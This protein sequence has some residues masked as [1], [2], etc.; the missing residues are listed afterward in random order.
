MSEQLRPQFEILYLKAISDL[1]LAQRGYELHDA[2]IDV[3]TLLF[4]LQQAAEKLLKA[5]IAFHGIHFEKVHDLHELLRIC[6]EN[7]IDIPEYTTQLPDLNPFAVIGRYDII[8]DI[9]FDFNHFHEIV[10]QFA[11]VVRQIINQ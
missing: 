8:D 7:K 4:H 9:E 2:H 5:L 10:K 6:K 1:T 11:D 3:A